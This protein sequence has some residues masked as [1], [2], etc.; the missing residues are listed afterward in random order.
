MKLS[1]EKEDKYIMIL[2]L[3]GAS[4]IIIFWIGWFIGPFKSVSPNDTTLYNTYIAFESSFPLP[5][6]WIVI[7]L[8]ASAQGIYKNMNYGKV[9]AASAGGSLIFL[10]LIDISF[11]IQHGIYQLDFLA[12]VI[13]LI[14]LLGGFILLYWVYQ[15]TQPN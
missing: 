10:A 1:D 14:S 5:D 3:M 6:T 2:E 15:R 9:F 4:A 7:S 11:N 8:L 12:I 13:N